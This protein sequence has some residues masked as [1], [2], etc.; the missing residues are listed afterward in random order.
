MTP[1]RRYPETQRIGVCVVCLTPTN[2]HFSAENEF[3]PCR[4]FL[5]DDGTP[6]QTRPVLTLV[7][8]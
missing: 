8:R 4:V 1:P 5:R 2:Q 3:I 6:R 7:Q